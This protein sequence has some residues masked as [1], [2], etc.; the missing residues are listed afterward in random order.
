MENNLETQAI[1]IDLDTLNLLWNDSTLPP[2]QNIPNQADKSDQA[3][4]EFERNQEVPEAPIYEV[5]P[6]LQL[7]EDRYTS[8]L[9]SSE[10]SS[11]E[12]NAIRAE[13]ME[14]VMDLPD[15]PRT[16]ENGVC[17][18][19]EWE[20]KTKAQAK[21]IMD[22]VQYCR[23]RFGGWRTAPSAYL[24]NA[25]VE[26]CTFKCTGS[27]YCEYLD[28]KLRVTNYSEVTA[29][30]VRDK[31]D[32]YEKMR[33]EMETYPEGEAI[34][35]IRSVLERLEDKKLCKPQSDNCTVV[36]ADRA[37]TIN[38]VRNYQLRCINHIG[39]NRT[40]LEAKHYYKQLDTRYYPN[41][42]TIKGILDGGTVINTATCCDV[43]QNRA[44]QL[45]CSYDHPAGKGRLQTSGPCNCR[46]EVMIP[47]DLDIYPTVF[48]TC[49]GLH[50]HPVPK[51]SKVL[52]TLQTQIWD[53]IERIHDPRLK[54]TGFA[55]NPLVKEWVAQQGKRTISQIHPSLGN[56]DI[57]SVLLR[58]YRLLHYPPGSSLMAVK[59]EFLRQNG[60]DNQYIQDFH[61]SPTGFMIICFNEA[62]LA[63]FKTLRTCTLNMNYKHL[64]ERNHREI[65]WAVYSQR[66]QKCLALFRVI[67]NTDGKHTYALMFERLFSLLKRKFHFELQWAHIHNPTTGFIGFTSDQ[68]Y[69][70]MFGLGVYLNRHYPYLTAAEHAMHTFRLCKVHFDRGVNQTIGTTGPYQLR[71]EMKKLLDCPTAIE[72]NQQ[73]HYL[74]NLGN[75][76]VAAW[77]AHKDQP[78]IKAGLNPIFSKMTL[79]N[80]HCCA[81]NSN[82]AEI[83]HER[84][85]VYSGR[86]QWLEEVVALNEAMDYEDYVKANVYETT[87]VAYSYVSRAALERIKYWENRQ[88]RTQGRKHRLEQDQFHIGSGLELAQFRTL[89]AANYS[90]SIRSSSVGPSD[91]A[92]N[93]KR[94][95]RTNNDTSST[96]TATGL[97]EAERAANVELLHQK[98]E[99]LRLQNEMNKLRL[100]LI[101]NAIDQGQIQE[102]QT[103]LLADLRGQDQGGP[104]PGG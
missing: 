7:S 42:A 48:V 60:T 76:Q 54:A 90:G 43:L 78:L 10:S 25:L 2:L 85:Y 3:I 70:V 13:C 96:A 59:R 65:I 88:G 77:A 100:S 11:H 103:L 22:E 79:E 39:Y 104:A 1:D 50:S 55:Q 101:Q 102:A 23:K 74:K 44:R 71:M 29:E 75:N 35:Y 28:P 93:A 46:F 82:A 73:I 38:G 87:H 83:L 95:K 97:D 66:Y 20:G 30:M 63:Y 19:V 21:K 33:Q 72:Y 15:Y 99:G 94:A 89:S 40:V 61:Q 27:K 5:I 80:F 32:I 81:P 36:V 53:L 12:L 34:T 49:T 8:I 9:L 24:N 62:M 64:I 47:L 84:S 57:F 51:P 16:S 37:P 58:R 26:R 18:A 17:Y 86:Y 41:I 68:D 52:G 6:A 45:R 67:T 98:A 14:G 4:E 31:Q 56:S 92:S 91:S 69:K